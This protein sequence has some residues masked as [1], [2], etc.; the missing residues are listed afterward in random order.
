MQV[1]IQILSQIVDEC[2][3]VKPTPML[4]RARISALSLMNLR[5]E[6]AQKD[7]N[8]ATPPFE[9]ANAYAQQALA[10]IRAWNACAFAE[11]ETAKSFP[12]PTQKKEDLHQ[13]LFQKLWTQY[14]I[15]QYRSDRIERYRTRIR[16]NGL[17]DL[18]KDGRVVDFGCG[19]ANFAHAAIEAGAKHVTGVDFGTGSL[20]YAAKIRDMLGVT[21]EQISFKHATVYDTGLPDA[22]YDFAIQNGVFHH[23]E[24]ED[25]AYR[26]V[27][28]VLRPGGWMWV[29]TV[30]SGA[31]THI[32]F[33][34]SRL[35]LENVPHQFIIDELKH[36]NLATGKRYN[37]GDS[38]IAVYQFTDWE[39]LTGRLAKLG[40]GN[41]QRKVGGF[42]T[43]FDHDVIAQDRYGPEKFGAG[44]LR[45]VCQKL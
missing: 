21:A 14:D 26:E 12:E 34:Y 43:D 45:F 38:M 37:L 5:W 19:H 8:L 3:S 32:M 20:E 44:D 36:L 29:Y 25:S 17:A 11:D 39:E 40:F 30:G 1:Y 41:F 42:D 18:F 28:R 23:L 10:T 22:S 6:Q 24:D 2:K 27:H 16:I 13:N 33:D 31:I 15:N 4:A 9:L 35:A 7:R